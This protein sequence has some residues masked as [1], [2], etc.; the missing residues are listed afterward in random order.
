MF[1]VLSAASPFIKQVGI[2]DLLKTIVLV[3]HLF[4]TE[5]TSLE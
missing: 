1:V 3:P 4:Y 5:A 2:Q